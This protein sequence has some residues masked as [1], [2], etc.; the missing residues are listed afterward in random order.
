MKNFNIVRYGFENLG[1]VKDLIV[2]ARLGMW[3]PYTKNAVVDYK[4][5]VLD[6]RN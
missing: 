6:Y 3:F 2:K 4:T 1:K 5:L